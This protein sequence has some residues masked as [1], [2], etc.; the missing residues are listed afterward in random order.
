MG[1]FK[2]V[3][4][5]GGLAGALL[6]DGL[7]NN[8]VE[9]MIYERDQANSKREGYQIRLG[10]GSQAGFRACLTNAHIDKINVSLDNRPAR[11]QQHRRS[12]IRNSKI[13]ST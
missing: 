4:V 13:S 9:V 1:G 7:N 5:G 11:R 2:V 6:A 12:I 3:I 8:G 10:R